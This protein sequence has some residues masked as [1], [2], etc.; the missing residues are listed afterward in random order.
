MPISLFEIDGFTKDVVLIT[1]G[2]CASSASGIPPFEF[3]NSLRKWFPAYDKKFYIDVHQSWYHK[4]IQDISTSIEETRVYLETII[5][6]YKKVIFMGVSAGGYAAIL[7]GSL[8]QVT[9]VV[10]FIPQTI[11]T[12]NDTDIHYRDVKQFINTTTR[13]YL[14]G[15]TSVGN[16]DD[17][18]HV[19][20]VNHLQQFSNVHITYKHT[21]SLIEM[22]NSGELQLLLETLLLS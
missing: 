8:L 13:Y 7:F 22:R 15:D 12:R 3:L 1:F 4:G 10:A 19:S 20:H 6:D 21:L 5:K 9:I 2:G 16:V 14:Y 18:H 17:L 11:L